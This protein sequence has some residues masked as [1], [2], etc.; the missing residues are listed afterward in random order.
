MR[1]P[2]LLP[3]EDRFFGLLR[4]GAE[5]VQEASHRLVRMLEDFK[6]A[7]AGFKAVSESEELG[8]HIIHDIMR[9]LHRTFVTPIDREDIIA[10]ADR[11]D[12]IVDHME[13]AARYMVSYRI[14]APTPQALEL[15]CILERGAPVLVDA[16]AKLRF[17]GSK[18]KEILPLTVEL[19]RLENEADQIASKAVADL[20]AHETSAITIIKWRD[21]YTQLETASDRMEDAANVLEGIVLKNA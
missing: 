8:D 19:N 5:N 18:L 6:N 10:L 7:E 17:R 14:A 16:V 2:S 12:D 9:N 11:I 20:F 3:K 15:A 13:E 21:I 1:L 4:S